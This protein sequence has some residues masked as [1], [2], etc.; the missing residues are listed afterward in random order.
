MRWG[1]PG[2]INEHQPAYALGKPADGLSR[3]E[4]LL[5]AARFQRHTYLMS[6][7]S[8]AGMP[9][10]ITRNDCSGSVTHALDVA[11][12]PKGQWPLRQYR[13]SERQLKSCGKAAHSTIAEAAHSKCLPL[14]IVK[15]AS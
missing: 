9:P 15:C 4:R 8:I 13:H 7:A 10:V 3:G 12:R 5:K 2:R 14:K 6:A 1:P 11:P